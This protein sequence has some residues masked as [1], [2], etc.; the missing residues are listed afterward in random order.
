M[1]IQEGL[2]DVAVSDAA[3]TSMGLMGKHD[4]D[5]VMR[6]PPINLDVADAEFELTNSIGTVSLLRRA[7]AISELKKLNCRSLP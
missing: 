2:T 4:A 1:I 3:R 7:R 6:H 5:T